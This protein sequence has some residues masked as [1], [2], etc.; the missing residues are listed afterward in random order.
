MDKPVIRISVRSLVE[1]L[2]R[3][4]DLQMGGGL[5]DREA[6]QKGSR[7]HRKIQKETGGDY[8]AEV[9]L[10]RDTEFPDL[11]I[12]V[13]G[14]ADGIFTRE[15]LT[16]I[17]EIKGIYQ[18]P[19]HLEAPYGVH[20]AQAMCYARIYAEMT[21]QKEMGV[22]MTYINL[23]TEKIRRFEET[24][25]GE[26]L[27]AWY[28]KL[29]K[30]YHRWVSY[31]LSWRKQRDASMEGLEF[32]FPYREGQKKMVAGV[33][34]A[35]RQ[36]KQIFIQAP[37]GVGK[38]MSVIFPAVRALGEGRGEALFY[39]TARTTARAVAEE[40]FSIL[41][42]K[43]LLFKVI[44]ITAREKLC[45]LE[46]ME[47]NPQVCPRAKGH[48]DRIN[49]AVF[50][51]LTRHQRFTREVILKQAEAYQVCPFEL[52]LDA[53]VWMDGVICDYNY[54]FDPNVHLKRFFGEGVQGEYIFLIDEAH[55]LAD[56]G[57]EM[58]SAALRREDVR[59]VKKL[60]KPYKPSLARSLE[61]VNRYLLSLSKE[62]ETWQKVENPEPLFLLL[63]PVMGE[64]EEYLQEPA[65]EAGEEILE[66]FFTLRDFLNI[67]D[68]LDE[69]YV[70]YTSAGEEGS[71]LIRLFCV[72][73]ATNLEKC[74]EKAKS[75]VFFSATLFPMGYYRKLLSTRQDD[76]GLYIPSPFPKENR[77]LLL[78]TDV[79]SRYTRRDYPEY[80][81]MAGYISL[82]VRQKKG[83]Y[84]AFFP[85]YAL[86][87][88][89]YGVY[90]QE[91][92]LPGIQCIC[93]TS[94]MTEQ[95]RESFLEEFQERK[96]S[97]VG[98][99]V[100]GGV[101]SEGIDLMGDRLIG[102]IVVGTGIP[103]ISREREILK[104]YYDNR[105]EDGFG[106]AYRTPGMNRV[107]QAAGRVIRTGEDVGVILLLDDRFGQGS[108]RALFP[109]EW[110][111]AQ[112]VRL[113]SLEEK[114]QAFWEK[115]QERD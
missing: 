95:E 81:R 1:F 57:R 47:C 61:R 107:L 36:E 72:N 35:I 66:F 114:L 94:S 113:E 82:T 112:Y 9:S 56:R 46:T 37:T 34:H 41:E 5:P 106:F 73:P 38:T 30:E 109:P 3:S 28:D 44:T 52:C 10:K 63:L 101:F 50:D 11:V 64:L 16:V 80:R 69:N 99:C 88:E 45:A 2:L 54:V 71:F 78:A 68:L 29:I 15:G 70:V 58:Y 79:S 19:E 85:S 23:D 83:N 97:L 102:V 53:A 62:C 75:T 20:K 104:E 60:V 92:S 32:P 111:D 21:G 84:M 67:S 26:F 110:E 42:D 31:Q 93:Q 49:E 105:G 27:E 76:Y 14:R 22:Q 87:E 6:M 77:C 18:N 33:Y 98:F 17:E 7:L 59:R 89:V 12:R 24:L 40:A 100:M 4:G 103:G 65:G 48:Y 91:F 115:K 39:L 90:Q 74:L 13:E 43:G 51:M 108:T 55:N 25:S 86:M 96:E 8:R